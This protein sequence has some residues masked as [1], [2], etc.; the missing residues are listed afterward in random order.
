MAYPTLEYFGTMDLEQE[1]L[2]RSVSVALRYHNVDF[3]EVFRRTH[4]GLC[5]IPEMTVH[6]Q[7]LLVAHLPDVVSS[8]HTLLDH[9]TGMEKLVSKKEWLEHFI[10]YVMPSLLN[11]GIREEHILND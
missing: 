11:H 2:Y 5:N 9:L 1:D 6:L 7:V 4:H 10:H 8:G 3:A